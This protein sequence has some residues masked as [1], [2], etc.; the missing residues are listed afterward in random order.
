MTDWKEVMG[1]AEKGHGVPYPLKATDWADALEKAARPFTIECARNAMRR[2]GVEPTERL[3]IT[4][5][6]DEFA[7]WVAA[8]FVPAS[9]PT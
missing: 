6:K 9:D 5:F 7:G 4:I 8:F 2:A 1:G 3:R